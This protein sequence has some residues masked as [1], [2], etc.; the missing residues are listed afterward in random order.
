MDTEGEAILMV[1][2]NTKE[3]KLAISLTSIGD[4][5]S[6][7]SG[8]CDGFGGGIARLLLEIIYLEKA[9]TDRELNECVIYFAV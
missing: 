4:L 1:Q 8:I 6:L 7:C 5:P 9:N 2:N 3:R